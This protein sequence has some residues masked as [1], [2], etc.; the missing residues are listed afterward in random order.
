MARPFVYNFG[1]NIWWYK[2]II[3]AKFKILLANQLFIFSALSPI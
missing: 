3:D 2:K 1:G